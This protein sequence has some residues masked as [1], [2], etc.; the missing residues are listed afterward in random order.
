[1]GRREPLLGLKPLGG[2]KLQHH[3]S[4][5]GRPISCD[6]EKENQSKPCKSGQKTASQNLQAPW[7]GF[8][9]NSRTPLPQ[10]PPIFSG[11]KIPHPPDRSLFN[12]ILFHGLLVQDSFSSSSHPPSFPPLFIFFAVPPSQ[13]LISF[14]PTHGDAACNFLLTLMAPVSPQYLSGTRQR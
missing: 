13:S 6:S 3:R 5:G 8:P 4:G 14:S 1:M 12:F 11:T 9:N 10:T 7:S 2:R